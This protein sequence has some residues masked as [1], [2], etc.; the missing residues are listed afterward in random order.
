MNHETGVYNSYYSLVPEYD[1]N[2]RLLKLTK[3][4]KS[5][6]NGQEVKSVDFMNSYLYPANSNNNVKTFE[7]KIS[8]DQNSTKR[9]VASHNNDDTMLA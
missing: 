7:Q 5:F 3:T 1:S 8:V 2:N 6:A 9:T 4:R